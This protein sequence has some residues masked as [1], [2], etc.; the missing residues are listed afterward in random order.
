MFDLKGFRKDRKLS[1][2]QISE[3]LGIGTSFISQIETG[4]DPM[5][6]YVPD[7]LAAT[8]GKEEV[9]KY[10]RDS[11]HS[12]VEA[13]RL[14]RKKYMFPTGSGYVSSRRMY[15][16]DGDDNTPEAA[17]QAPVMSGRKMDHEWIHRLL[18]AFERRDDLA[19]QQQKEYEKQGE[20]IDELL[21]FLKSQA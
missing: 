3:V 4:K 7:K 6:S 20:R 19:M 11:S 21:A 2:K 8:F 13:E 12:V 1:Q 15:D 9:D 17:A 5:P 14:L 16:F 18:S 10:F